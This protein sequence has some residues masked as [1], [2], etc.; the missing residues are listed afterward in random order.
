MCINSVSYSKHSENELVAEVF[1][2]VTFITIV[3]TTMI[4]L[5]PRAEASKMEHKGACHEARRLE[6][7]SQDP[8]DGKR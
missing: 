2:L 5:H 7:Y 6:F 4:F 1:S 8:Q 3:T